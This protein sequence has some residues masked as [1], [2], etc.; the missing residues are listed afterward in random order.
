MLTADDKFQRDLSRLKD[1]WQK[2]DRT[3]RQEALAALMQH[4]KGRALVNHWLTISRAIGVNPFAPNALQMSFNCGELQVGQMV[5]AEAIEADPEGFLT[6]LREQANAK[7]RR[8]SELAA[9]NERYA[10]ASADTPSDSAGAA[11]DSE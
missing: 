10:S 8:A 3:D 9:L 7:S 2:E 1:R 11:S 5:M 6:L 4:S